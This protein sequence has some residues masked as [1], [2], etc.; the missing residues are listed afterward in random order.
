MAGVEKGMKIKTRA[1][2][3][4]VAHVSSPEGFDFEN[5][6]VVYSDS[7]ISTYC[8][9]EIGNNILIGSEDPACDD[10]EWVDD[11]DNFNEDF[12]DQWKV[13][14]M[15][16][17][18]RFPDLGIPSRASGVVALYDVTDDWM[19]IYDKSDLPGF[20]MAIGTSGNQYKNAP[21]AGKIMSAI[22]EAC[23]K[24]HDHDADPLLFHLEHVGKNISLATFSRNREINQDSS[25][26]VIG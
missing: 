9:P 13:L 22:I 26:S 17:A 4:E 8:R 12:T 23:E 16:M 5:N 24:G 6:G 1:L 18:Q 10:K 14:V 19:P 2:R 25:F 7:A 20:Y 15:R 21:A 11:P 3:H